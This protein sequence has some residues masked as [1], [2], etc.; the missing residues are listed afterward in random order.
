M[1]MKV[2]KTRNNIVPKTKRI[3]KGLRRVPDRAYKFFVSVT[4]IKT[5]NARRRTRLQQTSIVA[6]YPYAK[7]LNQGWSRQ[8]PD[9]MIKPTVEYIKRILKGIFGR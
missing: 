7:R 4:P 2:T 1:R 3:E 9:G 6:D 5:G 8:A